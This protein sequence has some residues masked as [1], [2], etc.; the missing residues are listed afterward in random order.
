M[1]FLD[2]V[3]IDGQLEN[4][5]LRGLELLQQFNFPLFQVLYA[6]LL[7]LHGPHGVALHLPHI[8]PTC[9]H[10]LLA[11]GHLLLQLAD[12]AVG[13]FYFLVLRHQ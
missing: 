10:A 6:V 12:Y 2:I 11:L 8:E 5:L 4:L 1:G 9:Q 13:A 3:H 7:L